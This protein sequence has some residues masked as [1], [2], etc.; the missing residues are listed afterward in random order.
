LSFPNSP[1]SHIFRYI[2]ISISVYVSETPIGID[3]T[4]EK[5][6]SDYLLAQLGKNHGSMNSMIKQ[7]VAQNQISILNALDE[8]TL[9]LIPSQNI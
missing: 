5:D 8:L 7:Y 3:I 2:L 9:L 4:S 1:I 6:L